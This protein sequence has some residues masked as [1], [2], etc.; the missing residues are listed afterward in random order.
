MPA[1]RRGTPSKK[2]SARKKLAAKRARRSAPTILFVFGDSDKLRSDGLRLEVPS[3]V[4]LGLTL[5][6]EARADMIEGTTAATL[7]ERLGARAARGR[8]HDVVVVVAH[9]NERGVRLAS[10][11]FYDWTSFADLVRP[12]T[13]RRLVLVTCDGGR[14][15]AAQALFAKLPS[16][17]RIFASPTK[18]SGNLGG[19]MLALAP[20]LLTNKTPA[21]GEILAAQFAGHFLGGGQIRHWMRTRDADNAAG[22]LYDLSAQVLEHVFLRSASS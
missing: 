20:Y 1:T 22:V 6:S 21:P 7:R 3:L 8:A 16:L 12:L 10:D 5:L 18:A 13:P 17:R 2:K 4:A 9:G 14:W 19:L 15:P 11:G